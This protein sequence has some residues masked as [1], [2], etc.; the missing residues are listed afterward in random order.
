MLLSAKRI[1]TMLLSAALLLQCATG[2]AFGQASSIAGAIGGTVVDQAGAVVSGA[3]VTVRNVDTGLEKTVKTEESGTFR[4]PQ[5]QV[6]NYELTVNAAGF[7]ELKRASINV[8]VGDE[9]NLKLEMSASGTTE[10][11]N[12]TA[13]APIAEPSKTQ[14]S[15]TINDKAIQELPIN[16]RRWSNFVT[17][18]PGVTPDGS[19]GLI[20][21]R[22]ISGLLN[23][24]TIDGSDNN[25]AFFSEERGRTRINYVVGQESV[26]EFQV[27]TQNYSPEFGRAAGGVVNAV[28]KSGTNQIRGSAFYYLRDDALN[29][30]NPLDFISVRRPDGTLGFDV[31]KPDDRRQQFGGT[32]GGPIKQDTAFWFFSYDQQ[33]RNFPLNAQPN[34]TNFFESCVDGNLVPAGAC[35]R[36]IDFILPQTGV[37]SRSGDQWIFLPK[38]DWQVAKDHQFSASYNYMKWD[39]PNGI[40]TQPVVNTAESNNG[41]DQVRVDILNLR[42]TST[43]AATQLNEFRFQYGRDFEAQIPNAPDSVGLNIGSSSAGNQAGFN[44]GIAE[45]LPRTKFPDE[46][47]YQFVDNYSIYHGNHSFKFGGDLVKSTDNIDNLRFGAGYYNY[48][49]KT[50]SQVVYQGIQLFAIDLATPGA[51]NYSR[52]TQAFG[53]AKDSFSTWDINLF[54]QDEWKVRPNITLNY[55]FRYEY[56]KMPES[57]LPNLLVPET[58]EIPED[59]NNF[60]PRI[61]VAWDVFNDRKTVIRAG[62]GI[63]YGRIINSAVFN[64]RT[65]TGAQ[66]SSFNLD[67]GSTVG[68][69]YPAKFATVP[70]GGTTPKP[71][72][73]YFDPSIDTPE[74]RQADLAIER[75]I[76]PSLSVSAS[77]LYSRGSHLPFFFDANLPRANR[78]QTFAILTGPTSTTIASTIT[79]PIFIGGAAA[80]PNQ[81]FDRIM[82][83]KGAVKSW[84]DALVLQV[85]KR[86]SHGIQFLAHYT[87][88]RAEDLNQGSTTFTSSFPTALNQFDLEGERARS[89]F[90]V[91]NRFVASF[92]WE[93]PFAKENKNPF[94]NYVLAGWKLNG[95]VNLQDGTRVTGNAGNLPSGFT[96]PDGTLIVPIASSVNGSGGSNR[97]PFE[98]RNL[99]KRRGLQNID[100]R[101]GKEF[102]F[103][104]RYRINFI[105]EAFNLFNRTNWFGTTTTRF[106]MTTVVVSPAGSP[107]RSLPAFRPRTDFLR[108]NSA[109]S[110]L[111]RERQMQLALKFNF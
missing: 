53:L 107:T 94:A 59:K 25:Q 36:A 60:G 108:L 49:P 72:I 77:Y 98:E 89:N 10:V 84:Y 61:G 16:G 97:V 2:L 51:R 74:I 31:V 76:T 86:L 42:L 101:L 21:F 81:A 33:K 68:P 104:E 105:A 90:D 50:I 92:I 58:A 40:Q 70:S 88:A 43:L 93:I 17:L 15:T 55:G 7:G 27:N 38:V 87:L 30:R 63:Y 69:V 19:F 23:N 18:S 65:V 9:V 11:V 79:L 99:F 8:R 20:S 78:L 47:K 44:M 106:D 29:A 3:T 66:G 41:S 48:G 34:L 57:I 110:T 111:Y 45:F 4:V 83:Q 24:S 67:F 52:Y 71:S 109:Q 85:N 37:Y 13:E 32:V 22:G 56:I 95:I 1:C 91:K 54:A 64:G 26:K 82:V 5:L 28:T 96:D 46:R 103:K 39:S 102:R 35:R 12:V 14:V 80:R 6:G 100:L 75:E 62:W 73:F